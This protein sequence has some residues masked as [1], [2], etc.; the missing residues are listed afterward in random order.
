M[1]FEGVVDGEGTRKRSQTKRSGRFNYHYKQKTQR[2][3]MGEP[4]EFAREY[5]KFCKAEGIQIYSA[6]TDTNAAFA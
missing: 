1:F 3:W 4:L 5:D 2:N 6:L